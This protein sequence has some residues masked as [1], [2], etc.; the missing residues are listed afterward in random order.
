MIFEHL[1]LCLL[2]GGTAVI[3]EPPLEFPQVLARHRISACLLTVPGSTTSS[4]HC[5]RRTRREHRAPT[6]AACAC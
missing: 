3:P 4:T 6:C 5:A 2:G 1:G